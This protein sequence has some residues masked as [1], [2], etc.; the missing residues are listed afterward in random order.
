MLVMVNGMQA[1]NRSGTGICTR[2]LA[3]RLPQLGG[4]IRVVVAWPREIPLPDGADPDAFVLRDIRGPLARIRYDQFGFVRDARR[5]GADL[6]HY[7]ANVGNLRRGMRQIVTI[8]DLSFLH[9]PEWFRAGRALYYRHGV[10]RSVRLAERVITVSQATAD[11]VRSRFALGADKV[12]AVPNGLD[13]RFRPASPEAQAR[14]R[15]QYRLPDRFLLYVGTHE[16]RKNLPRLVRAWSAVAGNCPL[17]LVLAGRQGW[18]TEPIRREAEASPSRDRIHFPGYIEDADLPALLSAARAFVYPSLFEGF[19]LPVLEA[20][21]CEVPVVAADTSSLPEVAGD[22]AFLVDPLDE[23]ALGAALVRIATDAA[24]RQDLRKKG[25]D[26][27]K[28]FSWDR[29][30]EQ[31]LDVYR[32]VLGT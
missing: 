7:P 2:E 13:K 6:L 23:G 24:L 26:R 20:M 3:R 18:K 11:D 31:T 16:P 1:G 14:A 5:V 30:A 8:H 4:D 17:D 19:G 21:A 12:R 9:H 29:T 32:E 27:A 10:A 22:A 15:E 25:I 28:R